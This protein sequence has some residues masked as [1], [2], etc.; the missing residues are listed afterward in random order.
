LR[1]V[2][3]SIMRYV[4]KQRISGGKPDEGWENLPTGPAKMEQFI[5]RYGDHYIGYIKK[6]RDWAIMPGVFNMTFEEVQGDF[7]AEQQLR[8]L[9]RLCQ[10]L[11]IQL[12]DKELM[13]AVKKSLGTETVTYSGKRT[14]RD[15]I[16]SAKVEDFFVKNGGQELCDFWATHVTGLSRASRAA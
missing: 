6:M 2:F 15:N 9:R 4:A 10:F 7:G 5:D 14:S 16:W 8:S 13:E 12:G 3:V 1:D 11:G